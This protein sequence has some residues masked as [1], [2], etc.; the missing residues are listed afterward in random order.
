MLQ[1]HPTT[2]RASTAGPGAMPALTLRG[3]DDLPPAQP[4]AASAPAF[5]NLPASAQAPEHPSKDALFRSSVFNL[6]NS[7]L[8][9]GISLIPLP[10]CAKLAGLAVMPLLAAAAGTLAS[11]TAMM[12]V[13]VA[14]ATG[15]KTYHAAARASIGP[16]GAT[17]VQLTVLLNNFGVCIAFLDV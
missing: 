14:V 4:R 2:T 16:R 15:A 8:G 13:R 3:S 10:Y 12:L 11:I 9:G 7:V 6:S 17:A 5:S 1:A